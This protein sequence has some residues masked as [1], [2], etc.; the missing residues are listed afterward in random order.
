MSTI[1]LTM[2]Q[3]K[4]IFE[5]LD[6]G[7]GATGQEAANY[8]ESMKGY[9]PEKHK[10]LDDDAWKVNGALTLLGQL[11]EDATDPDGVKED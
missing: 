1:T 4:A 5:A 11:I 6:I 7:L 9:F 10:S 8:H 2:E 3:A